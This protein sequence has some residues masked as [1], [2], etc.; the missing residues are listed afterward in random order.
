MK[1]VRCTHPTFMYES[2]FLLS[3]RPFVAAPSAD[4]YIPT[5][6]LE[7]A[8]QT[9]IRCIDR[10]E[11]PGLIVGPAGTG[12]SLLCQILAKHFRGRFQVAH[13]A[14]TRL[15]TRRAL[16]QSIL[17]ELKLPY[18]EMDEGELRLSLIDHLEPR[19]GGSEGLLL[20]VDEAHTLPLRLLEEIRLLTNIVRDAQTR[21]RLVL[22]GGMALE[23]RLTS[24]KL[25][26]FH[27]RIAG[28]CYLQ[29]LGRDETIYYVQE[30]IR[31]CGASAD[32]LFTADAQTAVHVATDGIP[33]LINQVCDHGLMLAALGGH[34][35]LDADGIEEAWADL[36]QLPIPLHEP[37]VLA[38]RGPGNGSAG[39]IVEFGQL[40]EQPMIVAGTIGP[41][42]ADVAVAN[43]DSISRTLEALQNDPSAAGMVAGEAA[44]FALPAVR[45][46]SPTAGQGTEVELIF[47]GAHDPFGGQWEEEE[48][49]IDRYALLE[50]AAI[51]SRRVTSSE[52]RA[53]GA[54]VSA[55]AGSGSVNAA[56]RRMGANEAPL[57]LDEDGAFDPASDPLLPDDSAIPLPPRRAVVSLRGVAQ[58]DRDMIV[59][60][61]QVPPRQPPI[62]NRTKRPEYRQLFSTLRGK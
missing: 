52:G 2:H 44:A 39:G 13:L 36:Q 18:R 49:V 53:L 15:S 48:V 29:P 50:D 45:E 19:S 28:R 57:S 51:R 30:Q 17:F 58:D 54:A 32:T 21:V 41:E 7:Q 5:R 26:S 33:R 42:L 37:P 34:R 8:R 1:K 55:A 20:L 38:N 22:A 47:H 24:P 16:L 62:Q 61:D 3:Q 56:E 4:A 11:G 59:V 40:G 9:L 12:K 25:E 10:A 35:Q 60:E 43:L 6:S 27:Q 14:G 31:R 46:F 23:E